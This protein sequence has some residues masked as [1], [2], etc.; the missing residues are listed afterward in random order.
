MTYSSISACLS[1]LYDCIALAIA[2]CRGLTL[3]S[4]DGPLRKAAMQEGVKV[5]GTIGLLD[6]LYSQELVDTTEY[7]FCLEELLRNNG[8]KVRLPGHE[9]QRRLDAAQQK[10]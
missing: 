9:L 4:G 3:L 7:I 10:D 5:I 8:G 1:S 2:K 6:E